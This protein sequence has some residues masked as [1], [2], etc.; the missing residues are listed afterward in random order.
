MPSSPTWVKNETVEPFVVGYNRHG[1]RMVV[2]ASIF[3]FFIGVG[4]FFFGLNVPMSPVRSI[5]CMLLGAG[6]ALLAVLLVVQTLKRKGP[7]MLIGSTGLAVGF[8]PG[9]PILLDWNEVG[10]VICYARTVNGRMFEYVA[11]QVRDEKMFWSRLG[12]FARFNA[13]LSDLTGHQRIALGLTLL[14]RSWEEIVSAVEDARPKPPVVPIF[15][16]ANP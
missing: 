3:C 8:L 9:K 2:Q 11:V 10:G 4:M 6:L 15:D 14:D 12:P 13:W 1:L 7:A 5:F 16:T